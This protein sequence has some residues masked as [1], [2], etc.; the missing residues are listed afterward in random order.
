[1]V[2]QQRERA[3]KLYKFQY[4]KKIAKNTGVGD[5]IY[6]RNVDNEH[7]KLKDNW[8]SENNIIVGR[9]EDPALSLYYIRKYEDNGKEK[10]KQ[11]H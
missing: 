5:L 4:D 2:K 1:M 8:R 9:S 7:R 11:V 6:L 3:Q 10:T